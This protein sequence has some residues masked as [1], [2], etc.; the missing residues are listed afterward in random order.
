MGQVSL[1]AILALELVGQRIQD[2]HAQLLLGA[3]QPTDEML[4]HAFIRSMVL[5]NAV[6]EV[7]VG[8]VA[9]LLEQ[10]EGTV[11][12]RNVHL[13]KA[14]RHPGVDRLGGDVAPH[15]LD[16]FENE[17]ALRG[18]PLAATPKHVAEVE[19][20]HVQFSQL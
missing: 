1:E 3:A 19:L 4:V 6:V 17:L 14:H 16:R 18:H 7:G 12:G 15:G 11:D 10:L 5:G 8:H 20:R 13:G 9:K 2:V